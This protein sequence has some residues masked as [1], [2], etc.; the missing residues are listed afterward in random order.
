M[1]NS[2]YKAE[3]KVLSIKI[4]HPVVTSI[5]KLHIPYILSV[6]TSQMGNLCDKVHTAYMQN[7]PTTTISN[8]QEKN[9]EFLNSREEMLSKFDSRQHLYKILI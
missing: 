2:S 6:N 5:T 4:G 1:M 3:N 8:K 9:S 7:L